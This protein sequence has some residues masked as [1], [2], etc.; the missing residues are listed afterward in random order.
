[1]NFFSSKSSLL[2]LSGLLC[3][4]V[5]L[6]ACKK[7]TPSDPMPTETTTMDEAPELTATQQMA[8]D[9][10]NGDNSACTMLADK[11]AK[12]DG[13]EADKDKALEL[14][15]K[16]CGA[17]DGKACDS[18]GVWYMKDKENERAVELFQKSCDAKEAMGCFHLGTMYEKGMGV[19]VDQTNST[20]LF[21]QACAMGN[22]EACKKNPATTPM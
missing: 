21:K 3:A 11:Y 2:L 4:A 19:E 16:A 13:M 8:L 20:R 6:P 18:A 17:G 7:D 10:D 9:C 5:A 12:G 22:Q 15:G 1:M 14:Y